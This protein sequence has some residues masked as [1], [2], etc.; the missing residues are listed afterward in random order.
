MVTI[1]FSERQYDAITMK[2]T[3]REIITIFQEMIL[4]KNNLCKWNRVK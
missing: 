2:L 3:M 4:L 1:E